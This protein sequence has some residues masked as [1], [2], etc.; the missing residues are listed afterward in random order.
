MTNELPDYLTHYTT[1]QGFMGI[2]ESKGFWASNASF[3]NDRKELVHGLE[4]AERA[5]SKLKGRLD[6]ALFQHLPR[7][8][9]EIKEGSLPATYVTCFCARDDLLSQWRGYGGSEQGVSIQFP[10]EILKRRM[11]KQNA[12]LI[13]VIYS[14]LSTEKKVRDALAEEMRDLLE[15][16]KVLGTQSDDERK[17]GV[18]DIVSKLLPRFKHLGFQ[19]EREW[20]FVV[21]SA[22]NADD[23]LFRPKGAFI[24]PYIVLD[25]GKAKLPM[26]SVTIGPGRE[27]ELTRASVRLFLDRHGYKDVPV[28]VSAVPFRG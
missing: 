20:R 10:R 8:I 12:K 11:A 21:Q 22:V 18:F 5:I 4:G 17:A 23:L 13:K 24:A 27:M 9:Q 25:L 2:V 14:H 1:I 26:R 15:W 7:V 19:D 28:K 3:L 6:P 16:E